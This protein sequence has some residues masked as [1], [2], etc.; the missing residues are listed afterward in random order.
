MP[1]TLTSVAKPKD[2]VRVGFVETEGAGVRF[3][4]MKLLLRLLVERTCQVT[5]GCLIRLKQ[6]AERLGFCAST[7]SA[8]TKNISKCN[9]RS[10]RPEVL[11]G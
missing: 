5:V 4:G 7:G 9:D 2:V 6:A 10:V 1:M 11:E 8:R 3:S